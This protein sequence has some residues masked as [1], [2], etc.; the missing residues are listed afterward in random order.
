MEVLF[1]SRLDIKNVEG[2]LYPI[3]GKAELHPEPVLVGDTLAD[4]A[5]A[6]MYGTV[7]HDGGRYRMWYQAWPEDWGGGNSALVGYAESDNGMDWVK[8]KLG[9]VEYGPAPNNLCDLGFHAPAVFIDPDAPAGRRY[10]ATGSAAPRY[11]GVNPNVKARGYWTAHSADGLNW[12]LDSQAPTWDGGDVITSVYHPGRRC[13]LVALK[14]V[15]SSRGIRRRS[16]FCAEF[17][18]GAGT[19]PRCALVPDEFDDVCALARGF[20][21]ADYYGMG[22]LPAGMGTVGLLWQFRHNLPRRGD[23]PVG[24]LG[25]MDVSLVY[26]PGPAER[27]I[28]ASGRQDFITHA[29]LPWMAGGVY[30]A[31]CPIEVGDE[32]RL[33]L[34]G[35]L[36]SHGWCFD[37]AWQMVERLKQQMIEESFAK[38]GF[39]RWPKFRL[40]GFRSDPEGVLTVDVGEIAA[41][42]E[43]VLNYRTDSRGSIRVELADIPGHSL[44]DAVALMGDNVGEAAAWKGGTVIRAGNGKR[45]TA[46]IHVESAEVY[47]FEIRPKRG[48]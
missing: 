27:W 16:V 42:S 9:L 20:A 44:D 29:A 22:M 46:L 6:S 47:A 45:I 19:A 34:C 5:G 11:E 41:P 10:R 28:H 40:F 2:R 4:A 1:E 30:T 12:E 33:Y 23:S 25:V 26:Q 32:H 8:P 17:R 43:L 39:A 7:L 24:V 3:Q 15:L 13:G 35:T 21:S 36:C 48:A 31:S 18:D 38:I 37:S 14:H